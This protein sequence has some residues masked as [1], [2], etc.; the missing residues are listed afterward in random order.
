MTATGVV[1]R[2]QL[3]LGSAR[4][5]AALGRGDRVEPPLGGPEPLALLAEGYPDQ[6]AIFPL[7]VTDAATARHRPLSAMADANMPRNIPKLSVPHIAAF[8]A[9]QRLSIG[10][11]SYTVQRTWRVGDLRNTRPRGTFGCGRSPY[12]TLF[13]NSTTASPPICGAG[14]R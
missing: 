2:R 11:Q 5:H 8:P 14:K 12:C 4:E 7:D 10:D 6:R 13:A 3:T 1:R 9:L